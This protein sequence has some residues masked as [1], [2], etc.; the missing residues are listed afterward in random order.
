MNKVYMTGRLTKDPTLR[1]T[2]SGTQVCNFSV[3]VTRPNTK[4]ED[5]ISDFF[6]WVV[7]GGKDGTPGRAGVIAQYFHKGDGIVLAG[8]MQTRQ[9]TDKEG[10]QRSGIE[11]M[12]EDFE[13]PMG[14]KGDAQQREA[15]P[16][17]PA[18]PV[19]VGDDEPLPF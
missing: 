10:N 16:E 5:H 15:Q 18:Q 11:M 1:K 14:R 4:R 12:L 6:D 2:Q 13:F 3:A 19:Q 9:W 17:A 7:W 8:Y